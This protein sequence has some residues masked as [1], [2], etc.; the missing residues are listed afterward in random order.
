[1]AEKAVQE[2]RAVPRGKVLS[3]K[4]LTSRNARGWFSEHGGKAKST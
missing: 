1:M 2:S 4:S 3:K